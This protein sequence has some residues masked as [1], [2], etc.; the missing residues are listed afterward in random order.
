MGEKVR[1]DEKGNQSIR[2]KITD[3]KTRHAWKKKRKIK[4]RAIRA[5][6][7]QRRYIH[8]ET[9]IVYYDRIQLHKKRTK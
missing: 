1:K 3:R 5:G 2:K 4:V 7:N 9:H 6:G 8:Y